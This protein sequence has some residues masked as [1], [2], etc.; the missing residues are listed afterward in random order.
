MKKLLFLTAALLMSVG[1]FAQ[2]TINS[3]NVDPFHKIDLTGDMSVELI[4]SDTAGV[5]I[6][7]NA[8]TIDKLAWGVKDGVLSIRLKPGGA[9]NGNAEV[10]IY[11]EAIDDLKV[12]R[13]SVSVRDTLQALMLDVSVQAGGIFGG[14]IDA[15]DLALKVTGNSAS[16]LTGN[17]KYFNLAASGKSKVNARDMECTDVHAT[18]ATSAEVYVWSQERLQVSADSGGAV[19]YKGAPSIFRGTTSMMGTINNIG[20]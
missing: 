6:R 16:N 13:A 12:S 8:T 4:R 20:Q 11:Y 5:D 14:R 18:A 19:Y 1:A 7:L 2:Q 17:V 9:N 3:R 15:T 10:K